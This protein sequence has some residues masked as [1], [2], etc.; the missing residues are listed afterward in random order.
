M[1][2]EVRAAAERA[3]A[4][5]EDRCLFNPTQPMEF[6]NDVVVVCEYYLAQPDDDGEAVTD[7]WLL[8]NGFEQ[9]K[10]E[11]GAKTWTRW[12]EASV[13]RAW[14]FDDGLWRFEGLCLWKRL[15]WSIDNPTCR[16]LR[17]LIAAL[18]GKGE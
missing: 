1:T 17:R 4:I 6:E 8:A 18:T 3:L 14:K 2:S 15:T 16:Q 11:H 9:R 7:G 5:A 10:G 13:C 12:Q